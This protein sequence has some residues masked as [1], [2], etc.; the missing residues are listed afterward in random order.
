MTNDEEARAPDFVLGPSTSSRWRGFSDR[1]LEIREAR[2][3]QL[4]MLRCRIPRAIAGARAARVRRLRHRAAGPRYRR[5]GT[6]CRGSPAR[7]CRAPCPRAQAPDGRRVAR[8][9]RAW[10]LSGVARPG[11]G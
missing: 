9:A 8:R 5:P 10:A 2:F 11:G 3:L 4:V 6:A 1:V 7:A